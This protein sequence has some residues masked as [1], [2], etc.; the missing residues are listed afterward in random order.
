MENVD[1]QVEEMTSSE[2]VVVAVEVV[3]RGQNGVNRRYA[4]HCVL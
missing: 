3:P 1:T 4:M 2:E